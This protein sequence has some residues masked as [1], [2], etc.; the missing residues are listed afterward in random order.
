MS[1]L[2]KYVFLFWLLQTLHLLYEI[3]STVHGV[4]SLFR[5]LRSAYYPALNYLA[6]N[7]EQFRHD[8]PAN[9]L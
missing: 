6:V 8:F 7:A 3:N 5:F 9:A 4:I 2:A 1:V